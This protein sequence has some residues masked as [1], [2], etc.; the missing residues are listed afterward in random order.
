MISIRRDT[1]FDYKEANRQERNNFI[2]RKNMERIITKHEPDMVMIDN[3]RFAESR[4]IVEICQERDIDFFTLEKK[5]AGLHNERWMFRNTTIYDVENRT[6]KIL[7]SSSEPSDWYEKRRYGSGDFIKFN[8]VSRPMDHVD[9][10]SISV[11]ITSEDEM[12]AVPEWYMPDQVKHI[13]ELAKKT[14]R[15]IYVR[16]HPN[17]SG[18]DNTQVRETLALDE[19]HN[20]VIIR[21]EE[22]VDSYDLADRTKAALVFGSTIGIEISYWGNT[23]VFLIGDSFYKD[24]EVVYRINGV[25]ELLKY[26]DTPP[27]GRTENHNRFANYMERSGEKIDGLSYKGKNKTYWKGKKIKKIYFE[28]LKH[29]LN[30]IS[31]YFS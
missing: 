26:I 2:V 30:G 12:K 17:L 1:A 18:L 7:Q 31:R 25:Y 10:N 11:F 20:V 23:P 27:I 4:A 5:G 6:N 16:M 28:T 24:L 22:R 3:G 13:R 9:P 8:P 14:S 19:F 29:I 15:T 21:P